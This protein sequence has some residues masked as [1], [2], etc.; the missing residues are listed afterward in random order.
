MPE[1]VS[2][3]STLKDKETGNWHPCGAKPNICVSAV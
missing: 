1:R 2:D 3:V